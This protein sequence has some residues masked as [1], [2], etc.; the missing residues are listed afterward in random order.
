VT[1]PQLTIQIPTYRNPNQLADTVDSLLRFTE[2]PF[3]IRIINNDQNR[4][5]VDDFV[6]KLPV[7]NV[8]VVHAGGNRGWMAAH[9]MALKKCT[10]P[11]VCLLND[12]VLFTPSQ[13]DFWR[14]LCGWFAEPEIG[15]V[16]PISNFVMGSQNAWNLTHG[17][18]H[19]TSLLIGFCVVMRTDLIKEIGGLDETLPG[20]DDFDWSIRIR[21]AG[22]RLVVDRLCYLHHIGRQTG[23]RVHAA[24]D[25]AVHQEITMNALI[26]KHSVRDWYE[27]QQALGWSLM[28]REDDKNDEDV[29]MEFVRKTTEPQRGLDL[30]CGHRESI[31]FGLDSAAKGE[32]GA[33]GRK[34]Q[35]ALPG[36]QGDALELPVADGTLDYIVAAHLFE[37]LLNPVDALKEWK[38]ALKPG[39]LLYAA[40]PEHGRLDTKVI[41]HT[42][43]HAYTPD[44]LQDLL[45][46]QGWIVEG[47][48][49]FSTGAFGLIASAA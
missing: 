34:F 8:E 27:T 12:D 38:R 23:N 47:C 32:K 20:G 18:I 16:G 39:G 40:L 2:Y 3:V 44:S 24:W 13:M 30:G 7:D 14:R 45:I 21:K 48:K 31:G 11:Y 29:W 37:H 49:Q 25:G 5:P 28:K 10:T 35:G 36:I 19:E 42:H 17:L 4:V 46:S 41:D 43:V 26:R 15:A 22:Y 9:N 33:G 6:Q 1:E